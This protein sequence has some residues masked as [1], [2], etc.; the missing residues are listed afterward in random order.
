M[1]IIGH[2]GARGHAPENT[3][4]SMQKA[5]DLGADMVEFDVYALPSG[6]VVLMHDHRVDRTTSGDGRVLSHAFESLRQLD[7]GDGELVP[8][9]QEVLDLIDGKVGVN[10]ELKGPETAER[11]AG[12]IEEYVQKSQWSRERFLVSSFDHHELKKFSKVAPTIAIAALEH[13]IPLSYAAFPEAIGAVA[14]NPNHEFISQEYVN[15]AHKR[16]LKVYVYTVNHPEDIAHMQELGVDG[17]ITDYPGEALRILE[18][19]PVPANLYLQNA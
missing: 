7:A 9:L 3:L 19:Q 17:I 16:G 1:K 4:A 12:I 18:E 13:T 5:I 10:I 15:D 8:T 6:E 2:R 14:V 11:V